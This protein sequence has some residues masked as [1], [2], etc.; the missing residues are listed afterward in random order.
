[1]NIDIESRGV[2]LSTAEGDDI[3]G[4]ENAGGDTTAGVAQGHR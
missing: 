2:Y 3:T 4:D 1:M